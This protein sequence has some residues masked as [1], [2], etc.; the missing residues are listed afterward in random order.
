[1]MRRGQQLVPDLPNYR[2]LAGF[3]TTSKRWYIL[4]SQVLSHQHLFPSSFGAY[5]Q[6]SYPQLFGPVRG[7][8]DKLRVFDLQPRLDR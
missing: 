7:A 5:L 6:N 4:K 3:R 2:S 1:M 8:F